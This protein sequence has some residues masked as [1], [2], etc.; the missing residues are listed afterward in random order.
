MH[1]KVSLCG[2]ISESQIWKK[3]Q[4]NLRSRIVMNATE[5]VDAK[6][7]SQNRTVARWIEIH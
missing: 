3:I 4:R 6:I 2:M 5:R 7:E 1:L